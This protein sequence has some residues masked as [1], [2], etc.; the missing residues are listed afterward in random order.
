MRP[1]GGLPPVDE[2]LVAVGVVAGEAADGVDAVGVGSAVAL[3]LAQVAPVLQRRTFHMRKTH[4]F[5][6]VQPMLS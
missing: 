5:I 6:S 4:S 2:A 3:A 1:T